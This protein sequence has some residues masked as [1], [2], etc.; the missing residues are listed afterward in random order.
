M[1]FMEIKM[2]M[3]MIMYENNKYLLMGPRHVP[4]TKSD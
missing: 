1:D 2:M 4:N 3:M